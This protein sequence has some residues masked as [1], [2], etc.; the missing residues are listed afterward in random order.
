MR[1]RVLYSKQELPGTSVRSSDVSSSKRNRELAE[2]TRWG[3]ESLGG[4]VLVQCEHRTMY[5][6]EVSVLCNMGVWLRC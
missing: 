4:F 3:V 6:Y 1:S 5:S 2:M